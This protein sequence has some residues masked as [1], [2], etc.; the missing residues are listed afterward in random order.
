M[1]GIQA[2]ISSLGTP[3]YP[4]ALFST[5]KDQR[6][7]NSKDLAVE[8][9]IVQ[10]FEENDPP[11]AVFVGPSNV[12]IYDTSLRDGT[13]GESISVSCDD[14]LKIARHL[15]SFGVDFIECGWPGKKL[16]PLQ[17]ATS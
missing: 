9:A 3:T 7:C 5:A 11:D 12:L 1:A 2:F 14:K 8:E 17:Y 16:C 10:N 13:Q 4:S 15:S 6:N